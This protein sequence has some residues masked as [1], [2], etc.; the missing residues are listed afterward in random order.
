MANNKLF[1]LYK[2][3][4]GNSNLINFYIPIDNPRGIGTIEI[5]TNGR[6]MDL[7]P[8]DGKDYIWGF[9]Y[10]L[11]VLREMYKTFVKELHY[12]PVMHD[13]VVLIDEHSIKIKKLN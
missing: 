1:Q 4:V 12:T 11:E 7:V 6:V 2:D 8:Y 9:P 13:E 5:L 10:G 3:E